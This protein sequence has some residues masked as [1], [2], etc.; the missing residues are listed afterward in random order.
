[1]KILC[2]GSVTKDI[3]FP[4]D[5]GLVFETP[6]DVLSQ[7]K[8][9]FELG[10][11][12]HIKNRHE[13]LGGCPVNVACG[14]VRL[15]ENAGCYAPIGDDATGEWARKELNS[16]GIDASNFVVISNSYSDL[17]AI[18]VE[19]TSG[20]R[21]IFSDHSA[22]EK[23]EIEEEKIENPEWVFIGDLSGDWKKNL[24]TILLVAKEKNISLIFNPRQKAIHDDPQKNIETVALCEILFVNKDEAI[25]IVSATDGRHKA[26]RDLINNEKYLIEEL[27]KLGAEI[28]AITDG[29]RGAW[30]YDGREFL[31]VDAILQETTVDTTGAGD[32]FTSGFFAAHLKGKDLATSLKWGIANSSHSVTEYGGQKG[33]LKEKEMF[34]LADKAQIAVLN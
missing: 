1:M 34:L 23:F 12:Y 17:S 14:L 27:K 8:I 7:K 5:E 21:T 28:V 22:S 19:K 2:I 13:T 24:D 32:A 9:A 16:Q 4:T 11:K 30:A 18:I 25:E 31:H 6:N 15:G 10:A 20:D 33:L 3:F 26:E 29:I